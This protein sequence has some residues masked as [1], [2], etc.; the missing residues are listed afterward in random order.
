[1]SASPVASRSVASGQA[2]PGKRL[3]MPVVALLGVAVAA[4]VVLWPYGAGPPMPR[5]AL[6]GGDHRGEHTRLRRADRQ[7]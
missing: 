2:A 1:M 4:L 5:T 6:A 7:P 3:A